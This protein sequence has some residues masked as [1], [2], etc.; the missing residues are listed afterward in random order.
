MKGLKG[1]FLKTVK[2]I[3]TVNT[4]KKGFACT[5]PQQHSFNYQNRR[6]LPFY[7]NQECKININPPE[8]V[9]D[10][11]DQEGKETGLNIDVGHQDTNKPA[12]KIED[13]KGK[14]TSLNIDVGHQDT[15]KPTPNIEDHKGKGADLDFVVSHGDAN[16]P[17]PNIED[18]K[19]KETGSNIDVGHQDTNKPTPN[20]KDHK[21]KE[22]GSNIDVGPQNPK[23]PTPNIEYHKSKE[24]GLNIDVGHQ[25]INKPTTNIGDH[26]GKETGLNIDVGHQETGLNIDVGHQDTNKP[27]PNIEDQKG[28]E[29]GLN[30]DVGNQDTNGPTP[31]I[32]VKET[33][34]KEDH[35]P[36]PVS[37]NTIV[38]DEAI[39]VIENNEPEENPYL[40]DF[41]EKC[42]PGGE[43]SVVLYTTSLRG[44]RKTF[45]DC[46]NIKYLLSSFNILVH[47]RDVS[48]DMEFREELWTLFGERVVPPKLFIKGRYM[49]ELM[50]SLDCMKK[51]NLRNSSKGYLQYIS[52]AG[53]VPI[54]GSWFARTVMAAAS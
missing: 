9:I 36:L 4:L 30:I 54:C 29:N 34:I 7:K 16:I 53:N 12:P 27:T 10:S 1:R 40:K 5:N 42:P 35:S 47:E 3:P 13:Q 51:E 43:D 52:L 45:K 8:P 2:L 24:T 50:K 39:P 48:M 38:K 14:E 23:K 37:S 22:T 33:V 20:I 25:D 41:E 32:E 11:K 46:N 17:T 28:K 26:K 6:S 21:G 31:N 15:N 49:E 18:Q 19:G 44:I